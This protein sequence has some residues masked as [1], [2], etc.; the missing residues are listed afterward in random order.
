MKLNAMSALKAKEITEQQVIGE[1]QSREDGLLSIESA[2]EGSTAAIM[3]VN[4]NF[5]V[6]YVNQAS[7]NLFRDNA[8]EFKTAFP[9]FDPDKM[10]G[11]CIDV[12]QKNPQH[13]RQMLA[14][15]LLLPFKTDI[16]VGQL[17][18][19]LYVTATYCK[20]GLYAGYVLE[21]RNVTAE[22]NKATEYANTINQL[23]ASASDVA[24]RAVEK[25]SQ[26][27]QTMS[28][29]NQSV[30]KIEEI[31]AV[32]NGIAFQTNLLVFDATVEVRNLALSSANAAKEIKTLITDS[33]DNIS[34]GAKQ[35]ETAGNSMQEIVSSVQSVTDMMG[36]SV[37]WLQFCKIPVLIR[38]TMPSL[39][40]MK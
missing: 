18:I 16:Q 40:W 3:I 36:A 24:V 35:V 15:P 26:V 23:A 34:E 38:S 10:L 11:T 2:M 5:I 31:I 37:L 7:I 14:N 22:R 9:L 30:R 8:A 12:F 6:Y 4:R 33:L 13:Q 29:F 1:L 20:K 27:V 25:V 21:W 28:A 39:S 32:I 17:T 19:T